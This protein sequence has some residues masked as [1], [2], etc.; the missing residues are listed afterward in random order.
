M[1]TRPGRALW[2]WTREMDVELDHRLFLKQH[3]AL[4]NPMQVGKD[5]YSDLD[6]LRLQPEELERHARLMPLLVHLA[7]LG[8]AQRIELLK[9]ADDCA[10]GHHMPLFSALFTSD[11]TP[12][13]VKTVLQ[14][15]MVVKR[16]TGSSVWLRYH[17][18]RVFRHL[19]WL[20]DD[21]QLATLM[22]PAKTWLGY[23]PLRSSWSEWTRPDVCMHPRL[24]LS[25]EQ[26]QAVDE[27]EALNRC[28]RDFADE[29]KPSGDAAA[30]SLLEGLLA[31]R[32]QGL[33]Q[34]DDAM[35]YARQQFE[36]GE[37]IAAVPA[38]KQRLQ[39]VREQAMSYVA[40]CEDLPMEELQRHMKS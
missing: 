2:R 4:I 38:V 27:F 13:H 14:K 26:W 31:A 21:A 9:R 3:Y 39:Q 6:V 18:P 40:A 30:R 15:H 16:D 33:T 36:H 22:G 35:L 32:K 37:R 8:E 25:P 1:P 20:L 34:K 5:W 24:R 23:D 19:C 10:R 11:R 29:G 7:A 12:G 28:L 17:D